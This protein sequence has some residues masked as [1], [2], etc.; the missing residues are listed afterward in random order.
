VRTLLSHAMCLDSEPKRQ[1]SH[2]RLCIA[3][4]AARGR[5]GA[6]GRQSWRGTGPGTGGEDGRSSSTHSYYHAYCDDDDNDDDDNDDDDNDNDDCFCPGIG[7]QPD[8]RPIALTTQGAS[9]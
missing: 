4:V 2:A 5:A 1:S 9:V 3:R 8:G 6:V 7:N